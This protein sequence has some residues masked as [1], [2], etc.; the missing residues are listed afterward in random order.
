MSTTA[1]F[2]PM[3]PFHRQLRPVLNVDEFF[4]FCRLHLDLRSGQ[5]KESE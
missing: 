5:Q 2:A 1:P 3:A 4:V